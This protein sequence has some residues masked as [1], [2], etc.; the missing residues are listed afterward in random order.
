MKHVEVP[1]RADN[2]PGCKLENVRRKGEWALTAG[3]CEI[4][5]LESWEMVNLS[6]LRDKRLKIAI[7]KFRGFKGEIGFSML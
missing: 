5:L 3:P 2:G 4:L 7:E 6:S 1:Q